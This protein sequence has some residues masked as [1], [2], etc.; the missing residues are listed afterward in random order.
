MN[1]VMDGMINNVSFIFLSTEPLTILHYAPL[2]LVKTPYF[3]MYCIMY[4]LF[5]GLGWNY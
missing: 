4:W 5:G 3:I 2:K 1:E